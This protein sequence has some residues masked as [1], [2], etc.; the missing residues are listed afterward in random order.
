MVMSTVYRRSTLQAA[1][2]WDPRVGTHLDCTAYCRVALRARRTYRL[3][4]TALRFRINAGSW[5]HSVSLREQ[6]QLA[7]WYRQKLDALIAD[8]RSLAPDQVPFLRQMY[9]WHARAVLAH[10]EIEFAHRRLSGDD[11]RQ[12]LAGLLE[13]FP[14]AAQGRMAWKIWLCSFLGTGWLTALR[15][16]TRRPNP[17]ASR[18]ALF[19]SFSASK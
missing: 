16:L 6:R 1:G 7:V 3:P 15:R 8:A 13:L 5:G 2:G 18:L 19:N 17:Y 10:L 12:A 4:Q 9:V 14:E 11:L